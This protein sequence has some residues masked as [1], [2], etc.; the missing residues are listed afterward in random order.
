MWNAQPMPPTKPGRLRKMHAPST[1]RVVRVP[2]SSFF[3]Q[4]FLPFA[5][6]CQFAAVRRATDAATAATSSSSM[7]WAP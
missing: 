5:R 3:N 2:S 1:T 7:K 4:R 6:Y